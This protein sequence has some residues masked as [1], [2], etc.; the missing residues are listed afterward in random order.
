M[1]KI[2]I[3]SDH[4]VKPKLFGFILLNS[5]GQINSDRD[6]EQ[7]NISKNS[8]VNNPQVTHILKILE[9]QNTKY[10]VK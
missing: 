6:L 8:S 7:L 5:H 4:T 1:Y 2:D 3:I 10:S 9:M